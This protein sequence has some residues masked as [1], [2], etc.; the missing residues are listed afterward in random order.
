MIYLDDKRKKEASMPGCNIIALHYETTFYDKKQHSQIQQI[1]KD[2]IV[3][4]NREN[5]SPSSFCRIQSFK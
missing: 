1:P 2:L 4:L 5:L 3:C